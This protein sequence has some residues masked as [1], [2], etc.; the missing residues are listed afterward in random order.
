M[1]GAF[2]GYMSANEERH[3]STDSKL[4]QILDTVNRLTAANGFVPQALN[5]LLSPTASAPSEAAKPYT[6]NPLPTPEL[7]ATV[8]KVVS[9][10]RGRI[11]K[12]KGGA[13]DNSCKEHARSTFYRMLGIAAAREIRPFF[14]DDYGEPDTLPVQFVDPDTGYC[15]PYPHWKMPLTKQVVWIP[16][17]VVRF[18]STIPH[19]RSELSNV[20]RA[21]SDEQIVIL[22]N[23]G[24]FK[25]AQA[26][27]RDFKKT[28]TEI[29]AMRSNARRYQRCDRKVAVRTSYLKSIPSLQGPEWEYLTQ[30][31]YMSQ[32]ESDAEGG[33]TT[34][35]PEH[36]AKWETNL[37]DAI[38]VAERKKAR[39][40][41]GLCSH[42]PLRQVDIVKRPVPQLERGTGSSKVVIR[43]ALCRFSKSWREKNPKEFQK[44]RHLINV[45]V[46]AKPDINSFLAEN[47]AL[48][49]NAEEGSEDKG[50]MD[51]G[52]EG[53]AGF[54]VDAG[55]DGA[56]LYGD[57]KDGVYEG[58][59]GGMSLDILERKGSLAAFGIP[60]TTGKQGAPEPADGFGIGEKSNIPID[61]QL[62][63]EDV[64]NDK[65]EMGS[66]VAPQFGA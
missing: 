36:R 2:E 44:Y 58:E 1:T 60:V 45:K 14:E 46:A 43:I 47:P 31:G 55:D 64:H 15:R 54:G 41:P 9:E 53:N 40:K 21:L 48:D 6:S 35:R 8:S 66:K 19:D 12:K 51:A 11:G 50:L 63:G 22:L 61:P 23:D 42:L 62:S 56:D 18:R 65:T 27:W 20:L 13:D 24:P 52:H 30:A 39:A 37:F 32:D 29:E 49:A 5:H 4:D 25:S 10:A 7:I 28:D 16:T 34:K 17:Y 33:I 57:W 26:A 3:R 59:E 38:H